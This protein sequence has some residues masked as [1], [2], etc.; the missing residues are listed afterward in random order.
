VFGGFVWL[1]M[2]GDQRSVLL[3]LERLRVWTRQ[4]GFH[5]LKLVL[6]AMYRSEF[7]F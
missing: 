5:G 1:K 3:C 7:E 2:R 4:S 6:R